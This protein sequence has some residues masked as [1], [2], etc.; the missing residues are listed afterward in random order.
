MIPD[1]HRRH[2]HP[3]ALLR[4]RDH[5]IPAHRSIFR[6]QTNQ[7][8][9][10]RCVE[11]PFFIHR[12]AAVPNVEALIRRI[13]VMP[14]LVPR[15][16]IHCPNIVRHRD[17]QNAVHHQRRTLQLAA[18]ARLETPSQPQAIHVLRRNLRERTMPPTRVITV[19]PRPTIRRRLQLPTRIIFLRTRQGTRTHGEKSK[20]KEVLHG[21]FF[22][23]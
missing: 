12:N 4:I 19:I 22:L 18:L 11:Q 23:T 9:I 3:I 5:H 21:F 1:H 13:P 7:V 2:R 17:V 16:R 15:A 20:F 6:I 10:R 14:Q 8:R